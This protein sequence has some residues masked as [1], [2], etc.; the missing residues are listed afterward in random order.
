M[1]EEGEPRPS[2]RR[3]RAGGDTFVPIALDP[4]SYRDKDFSQFVELIL[5]KL[6]QITR[7]RRSYYGGLRARSTAWVHR[8]RWFLAVAGALALLL[9]GASAALQLDVTLQVWSRWTLLGALALYAAMG[10]LTFYDRTTDVASTYFRHVTVILTM[11][12]LWTKLQ[13]EVLKELEAVRNASDAKTGEVT[14]RDRIRALAEAY[15]SDLDKVTTSE[16]TEWR[17]EF[18]ASLGEL[19]ETARKGNEDVTKR[20][21]EYVKAAK[22]AATDAAAAA[23]AAAKASLPGQLNVTISGTFDSDV[24]VLVDGMEAARSPGKSIALASVRVGTRHVTARSSKGGK[25]L[26]ASELVDVKSGIQALT[27]SF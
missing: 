11:R 12:D 1:T 6:R 20:I 27:L 8:S 14:A 23:D 13:F 24:V 17:A 5:A 3:W 10:A 19:E 7:I 22:Q 15:C 26:E 4:E 25:P 21:E 16:A 18:Q 2:A 9:T